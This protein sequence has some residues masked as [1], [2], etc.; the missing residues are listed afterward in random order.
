MFVGNCGQE[1]F[2]GSVVIGYQ[3]VPVQLE[4]GA[5]CYGNVAVDLAVCSV[6]FNIVVQQT[7]C[8][9]RGKAVVD[10]EGGNRDAQC[11]SYGRV[12]WSPGGSAK[13]DYEK[14][15]SIVYPRFT[16]SVLCPYIVAP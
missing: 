7:E 2:F 8:V 12:K 6:K 9:W 15:S 5:F 1:V 14:R 4:S 16:G 10:A 3:S 13:R 11:L